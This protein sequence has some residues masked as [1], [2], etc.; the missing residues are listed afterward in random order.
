MGLRVFHARFLSCVMVTSG[1]RLWA[2]GPSG[3]LFL[4]VTASVESRRLFDRGMAEFPTFLGLPM[5]F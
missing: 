1:R 4:W 2:S 5:F 3:N